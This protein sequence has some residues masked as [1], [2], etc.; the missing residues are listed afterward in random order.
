MTKLMEENNVEEDEKIVLSVDVSYM[1]LSWLTRHEDVSG[2]LALVKILH[3]TKNLAI[4]QTNFVKSML[5]E[6]E[7]SQKYKIMLNLFL[8]FLLYLIVVT[9]MTVWTMGQKTFDWNTEDL[10]WQIQLYFW[11]IGCIAVLTA[12]QVNK[13]I[14]QFFETDT[15]LKYFRD[16][17][18]LLDISYL[19]INSFSFI[20]Y[21]FSGMYHLEN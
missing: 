3:E 13:E 14:L 9:G 16:P 11:G 18:N 12:N 21:H 4:F 6:F 8:P 20:F 1:N 15:A 17:R 7:D 2:F 5:H 10:T 19:A